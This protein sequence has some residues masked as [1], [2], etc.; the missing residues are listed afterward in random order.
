MAYPQN[1]IALQSS[2]STSSSI[3][4]LP[5]DIPKWFIC[6]LTGLIMYCP[7][8]DRVT[9]KTYEYEERLKQLNGDSTQLIYNQ[10]LD[11]II[12]NHLLTN[13]NH[14]QYVYSSKAL[15]TQLVSAINTNNQ[16]EIEAILAKDPR[17]L[18]GP[19]AGTANLL[20]L[21]MQQPAP[22]LLNMVINKLIEEDLLEKT[23]ENAY[24]IMKNCVLALGGPGIEDIINIFKLA[25]HDLKD[26]VQASINEGN[27][28]LLAQLL[29]QASV[30]Q[31]INS[32]RFLPLH[33]A[34]LNNYETSA[35]F[36][37]TYHPDWIN[38]QDKLGDTPTHIAGDKG[39][40]TLA[41][42]LIKNGAN[43]TILNNS[44]ARSNQVALQA[45]HAELAKKMHAWYQAKKAERITA[46]LIQKMAENESSAQGRYDALEARCQHLEQ[47]LTSY[48]RDNHQ[49]ANEL[50]Q[51]KHTITEL[52]QRLAATEATAADTQ[53]RVAQQSYL[54]IS[55]SS[56]LNI[57]K[58]DQKLTPG[59]IKKL[60]QTIANIIEMI[61]LPDNRA[62][63]IM[64]N[65]LVAVDLTNFQYSWPHFI[66]FEN[67]YIN[68]FLSEDQKNLV[69]ITDKNICLLNVTNG[70]SIYSD[71]IVDRETCT[72]LS[73]TELIYNGSGNNI[74]ILQ[75]NTG[76]ISTVA[77][78]NN[79][80]F[81]VNNENNQVT[82]KLSV[83]NPLYGKTPKDN[84]S[85]TIDGRIAFTTIFAP[86]M[87][88]DA[89]GSSSFAS[90]KD[91]YI[92]GLYAWDFNKN[93]VFSLALT[94]ETKNSAEADE[95]RHN[96]CSDRYGRVYLSWGGWDYQH[97]AP[98]ITR[99]GDI[100]NLS[101]IS[102]TFDG[103]R[104]RSDRVTESYHIKQ[105]CLQKNCNPSA[106]FKGVLTIPFT[107]ITNN[108]IV[109]VQKVKTIH[110]H[111]F[112]TLTQHYDVKY[113]LPGHEQQPVLHEGLHVACLNEHIAIVSDGA[114]CIYG[115]DKQPIDV[116]SLPSG[117][118]ICGI[119]ADSFGQLLAIAKTGEIYSWSTVSAKAARL[120]SIQAPEPL[121]HR[122]KHMSLTS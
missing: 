12:K 44:N 64:A 105:F 72:R 97:I 116:I 63:T 23:Q 8:L 55:I 80:I 49:L 26:C 91:K 19:I 98:T 37:A 58:S 17:L 14:W 101:Y 1:S 5:S 30:I 36:L 10:A 85:L 7:A 45:G 18:S 56:I 107:W 32:E 11:E 21:T 92:A 48:R 6:S 40:E 25:A 46:P 71:T 78:Q 109:T 43:L 76:S 111:T 119:I 103:N 77:L 60:P 42:F 83:V 27:T 115:N 62:I 75:L 102:L 3:S 69:L 73:S 90:T 51:S 99:A 120:E 89:Q 106:P 100:I 122:L 95:S 113:S 33:Y 20:Q 52:R 57:L 2:A 81:I 112:T 16:Q 117:A 121:S 28:D 86:N 65:C 93:Q 66:N 34:V 50:N 53:N 114:I 15:K 68:A 59:P 39:N 108:S 70:D 13:P 4:H 31:A 87:W 118:E 29:E 104:I 67:T 96:I 41:E 47:Q 38:V 54:A 94:S 79:D 9:S 74:K 82:A 84:I 61:F 22:G 35:I 110:S 24:T 88:P